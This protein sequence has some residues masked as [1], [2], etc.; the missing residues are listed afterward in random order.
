LFGPKYRIETDALGEGTRRG[1]TW[2]GDLVLKGFGD[3]SLS[4]AGLRLL[5]RRVRAHGIRTIAGD[6][7]ADESFFDAR[8]DA[9]GWKSYFLG[10]ECAPLSAL[11]VNRGRDTS[12]LPPV[13]ADRIFLEALSNAGVHVIGTLRVGAASADALPLASLRSPPLS[14]LLRF[15]DHESDNYT[16]ELLLKQVGTFDAFQGTTANGAAT[17]TDVLRVAGVPLANV[18]IVDGSGL[19]QLDRLTPAALAAVL[20]SVWS[21]PQ[22]RA[23]FLSSLAVAGESGTLSHRMRLRPARGNVYAKTGTTEFASALSGYVRKSYAFAILQNGSPV[24]TGAAR[25]SQDRFAALLAAQ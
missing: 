4:S 19:S 8:R 14:E 24:P 10:E 20:Q 11:S 3:P 17:V 21:Y 16:A 2:V 5:A 1:G 25:A 13:V 6:L 9:P 18:R 22:F 15:M 23:P 12:A 7:V